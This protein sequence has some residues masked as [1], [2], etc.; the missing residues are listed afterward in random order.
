ML[1]VKFGST[2]FTARVNARDSHSPGEKVQLTFNIAKGHFFD[3]ETE[4]RIN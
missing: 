4:K 3:L 2:E 1:Y